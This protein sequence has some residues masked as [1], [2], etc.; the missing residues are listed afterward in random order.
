MRSTVLFEC[1]SEE[2]NV[3]GFESFIAPSDVKMPSHFI[4]WLG[5]SSRT[6]KHTHK[7]SASRKHAIGCGN[8]GIVMLIL[9]IQSYQQT[10]YLFVASISRST[11]VLTRKNE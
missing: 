10:V 7:K 8:G 5:F 2:V 9:S 1:M 3:H 6:N 4:R 11:H